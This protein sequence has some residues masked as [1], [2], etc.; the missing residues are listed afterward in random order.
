MPRKSHYITTL[1]RH[2]RKILESR[3]RKYTLPYFDVIRA[4][5]ILLAAD[6]WANDEI[7][8]A[9]EVRAPTPRPRPRSS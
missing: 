3:S 6:G 9:L 4:K 7:A 2:E 1:S 8:A 5:M